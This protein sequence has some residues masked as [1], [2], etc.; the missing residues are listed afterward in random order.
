M[1]NKKDVFV[2]MEV[3]AIHDN[4]SWEV[5][6]ILMNGVML[7]DKMGLEDWFLRYEEIKRKESWDWDRYKHL[8]NEKGQ[9]LDDH[10]GQ[11][12]SMSIFVFNHCQRK[13]IDGKLYWWLNENNYRVLT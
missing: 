13:M 10:I 9:L 2:G 1:I 6:E 8:L 3:L 4:S 5:T 11:D 12:N 7:K